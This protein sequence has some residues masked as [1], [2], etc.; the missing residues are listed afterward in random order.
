MGNIFSA[1]CV[2]ASLAIVEFVQYRTPEVFMIL[3]TLSYVGN[4][5]LVLQAKHE[6]PDERRI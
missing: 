4:K 5:R 1:S 6:T 2:T 3:W